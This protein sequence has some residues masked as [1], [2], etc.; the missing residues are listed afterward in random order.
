MK[1]AGGQIERFLRKPDAAVHAI[2]VY[3]PD[4]GL[5]SERARHWIAACHPQEP[6]LVQELGADALKNEPARL[7]DEASSY[8]LLAG[9][10]VLRVRQADDAITPALQALLNLRDPLARTVIEAGDLP[11][12]SKLRKLAE[13]APNIATIACYR[14]SGRELAASLRAMLEGHGID[15][16]R[17]ASAYLA[18][19]L[20][21]D[22]Q[23][24]RNEIDKLA[25]FLGAT[26]NG[27]KRLDLAT[28]S[29]VVG[30]SSAPELDDFANAVLLGQLA[31]AER[32][33]SHL[34]GEGV[35]V[36]R[37]LRALLRHLMRLH[38]LG[39][40]M[41]AGESAEAAVA[42]LKPPVF[43]RQKGPLIQQTRYWRS[44]RVRAALRALSTA[45]AQCKSG[46][47]DDS[48]ILA[49]LCAQL[50]RR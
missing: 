28:A 34:L 9:P 27:R 12:R 30:D 13:K 22:H 37:M 19:H 8:D 24:T 50:A 29:Q 31:E 26:P 41:E 44:E 42:G 45:E 5:A 4:Q 15:A 1:L 33:R 35:A 6:P 3:G 39:C 32:L 43:F 46:L 38:N 16:D 36:V 7:A 21:A 17:D 18:E 49:R 25:L 14:E 47:F 20:G 2:L 23:M 40:A 10:R 11:P 48:L